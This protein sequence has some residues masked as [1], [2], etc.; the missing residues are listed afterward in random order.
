MAASDLRNHLSTAAFIDLSTF[1]DHEHDLPVM[2]IPLSEVGLTNPDPH[3]HFLLFLLYFINSYCNKDG[4]FHTLMVSKKQSVL[5]QVAVCIK[6]LDSI[7]IAKSS[8]SLTE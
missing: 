5:T 8:Y 4:K 6:D 7:L 2:L 1:N 3:P